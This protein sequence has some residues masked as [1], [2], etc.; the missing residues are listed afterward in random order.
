MINK[1][2]DRNE[3]KSE[4]KQN[5]KI[6]VDNSKKKRLTNNYPF[7]FKESFLVKHEREQCKTKQNK[8]KNKQN[9]EYDCN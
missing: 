9:F 3:K 1:L 4:I 8:N 7:S 6:P 2:I 5:K